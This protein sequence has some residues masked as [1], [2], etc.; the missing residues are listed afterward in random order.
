MKAKPDA[1]VFACALSNSAADVITTRLLGHLTSEDIYRFYAPSRATGKA[2]VAV[3]ACTTRG[4]DGGFSVPSVDHV[5]KFRVIVSTCGSASF[6]YSI[7][8]PAGHFSHIF[9]DESGQATEPEVMVPIKTMANA[10]T[11]IVLSGD[12]KQLGPI[13]R[14]AI[15]KELGLGKSYLERLMEREVYDETTGSGK[16]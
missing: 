6:A 4:A 12:P 8:V 15:A 3:L 9:V 7:G 2:P 16:T 14:S 10:S 11:N 1:H 5:S 13:V